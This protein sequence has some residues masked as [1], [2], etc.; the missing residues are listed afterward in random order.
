[1]TMPS[2]FELGKAISSN[3]NKPF[4]QHRDASEIDQ[5]L[6]Q[7]NQSGKPEDVDWAMNQILRRVSPEKQELGMQLL[8]NKQKQFQ[9]RQQQEAFTKQGLDPSI[10]HLP[11][12]VQ[13]QIVKNKGQAGTKLDPAAQKWAYAQLDK[14][15]A[16]KAL[17]SSI[18]ELKKLNESDVTG[19]GVG[20]I[21]SIFANAQEDAIRKA[22]DTNAIQ[23]LNVHKSMFPRGITGGEF[24]NLEKKLVSSKNTKIANA[25][26]LDSYEKLA[27]LQD[28]KIQAVEEATKKYGF[29]PMLPF[30]VSGIQK[31]FDDEEERIN[32]DLYKS[33]MGKES[34]EDKS[35]IEQT[36]ESVKK[37]EG[38][39]KSLSEIFR[40]GKL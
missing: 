38:K 25:A 34:S 27:D 15:P 31:Q 20:R 5:I 7:A 10:A 39:K 32:R 6:Q 14:Q 26:I 12:G 29:D 18:G 23:L 40:T 16:V 3:V 30:I 35:D 22:I 33:V 13:N 28:K 36:D 8:Q 2:S 37:P 24:A 19:P 9:A 4:Q 11:S 21:P 17:K 1:M